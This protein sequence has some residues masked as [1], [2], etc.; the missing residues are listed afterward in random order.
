MIYIRDLRY[1]DFKEGKWEENRIFFCF[2]FNIC[3]EFLN[4][5]G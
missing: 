1:K 2:F 4:Y 5:M 3:V